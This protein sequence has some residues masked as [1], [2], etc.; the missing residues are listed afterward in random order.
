MN[1][2]VDLLRSRL[3]KCADFGTTFKPYFS[4]EFDYDPAAA[5]KFLREPQLKVL[6]PRLLE[7]YRAD[8]AFTLES[9]E[10]HLRDTAAEA[11][12][13]AGLLINALRVGLTGQG[14]APSL[15]EVMTV[16]GRRRTLARIERL[17]RFL[18]TDGS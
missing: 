6:V 17:V 3:R 2:T 14:V 10:K 7:R 1:A 13:K 4:D 12:V 15:F 5:D 11:G 16:L 8:P 9:T 18:L